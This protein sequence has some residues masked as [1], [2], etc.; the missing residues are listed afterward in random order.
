MN[1]DTSSVNREQQ[2]KVL[3]GWVMLPV[4]I[5]L[6]IGGVALFIYSLAAGINAVN[7][8]FWGSLVAAPLVEEIGRAHV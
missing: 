2:V 7:H 1:T 8:P 5:L 3:N 6:L 4:V